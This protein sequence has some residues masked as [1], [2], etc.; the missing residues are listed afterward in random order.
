MADGEQRS[1]IAYHGVPLHFKFLCTAKSAPELF[2]A[3]LSAVISCL[4]SCEVRQRFR[5]R[6]TTADN[7]QAGQCRVWPEDFR[8]AHELACQCMASRCIFTETFVASGWVLEAETDSSTSRCL[9]ITSGPP[10]RLSDNKFSRAH[11]CHSLSTGCGSAC[12]WTDGS[13]KVNK[14]TQDLLKHVEAKFCPGRQAED[15]LA[16]RLAL[17]V[18][19]PLALPGT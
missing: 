17:A 19:G 12:F 1:A 13:I 14:L 3:L 6:Y 4:S 10:W 11:Q 9:A 2:V 5:S 16:G 18:L 7:V 8:A 15:G